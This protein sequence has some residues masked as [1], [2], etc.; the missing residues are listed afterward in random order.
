MLTSRE[1]SVQLQSTPSYA[2]SCLS[3]ALLVVPLHDSDHLHAPLWKASAIESMTA[4]LAKDIEITPCPTRHIPVTHETIIQV[5]IL[6]KHIDR[7]QEIDTQTSSDVGC[8]R[9]GASRV[10]MALFTSCNM[11]TTSSFLT[12]MFPFFSQI[13]CNSRSRFIIICPK[14]K[15]FV[16]NGSSNDWNSLWRFLL[17]GTDIPVVCRINSMGVLVPMK[18]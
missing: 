18:L 11:A 2:T 4:A 13:C 17:T 12:S 14:D 8:V 3:I 5:Q 9:F 7:R 1:L 10:A 6:L 16:C 15:D